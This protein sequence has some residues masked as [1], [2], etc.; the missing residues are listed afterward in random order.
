MFLRFK[1]NNSDGRI[2]T[3]NVVLV[4]RALVNASRDAQ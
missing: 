3:T 1:S 4:Y 2:C